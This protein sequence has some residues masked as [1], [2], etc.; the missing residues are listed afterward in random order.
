[1]K[2][3]LVLQESDFASKESSTGDELRSPVTL[4]R[5]VVGEMPVS[6]TLA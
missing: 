6:K 3:R 2:K 5:A 1:M 4:Q